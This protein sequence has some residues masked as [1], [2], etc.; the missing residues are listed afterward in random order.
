MFLK[1]TISELKRELAESFT[2]HYFVTR[3]SYSSENHEEVEVFRGTSTKIIYIIYLCSWPLQIIDF[4]LESRI[5][6]YDLRLAIDHSNPS[7]LICFICGP[8]P[9]T[10]HFRSELINMGVAPQQIKTEK[11]W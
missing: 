11:W 8:P 5:T 1:E 10:D 2:Y 4:T 7:N 6:E 9:M 3:S